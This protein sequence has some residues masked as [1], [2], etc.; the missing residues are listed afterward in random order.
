MGSQPQSQDVEHQAPPV[1]DDLRIRRETRRE[2][3]EPKQQGVEEAVQPRS[4]PWFKVPG[5]RAE[6]HWTR[7]WGPGLRSPQTSGRRGNP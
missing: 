2:G 7:G 3:S 5:E 1:Q 6:D 4:K